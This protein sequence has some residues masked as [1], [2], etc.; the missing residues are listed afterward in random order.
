M[1]GGK[2]SQQLIKF[3]DVPPTSPAPPTVDLS[4]Y[5]DID[6]ETGLY[7]VQLEFTYSNVSLIQEAIDNYTITLR[8]VNVTL[9][10][11]IDLPRES[12]ELKTVLVGVITTQEYMIN[13]ARHANMY[14]TAFKEKTALGGI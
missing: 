8:N 12:L 10:G 3:R 9:G 14:K 2:K 13:K 5:R 4:C 11:R 7:S 1:P 6:N